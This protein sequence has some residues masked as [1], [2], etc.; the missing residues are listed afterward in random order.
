MFAA[1]FW[2]PCQA[3]WA[4]DVAGNQRAF[5]AGMAHV[6]AG[7][8]QTA[9][10]VFEDL[11]GRTDAPRVRLEL[12]RTLFLA[13]EY[14]RSRAEFLIVYR[15]DLP[16]PVRR[17][18]NLFLDDID[19]RIGFVQPQLGLA[20]DDNPSQSAAS[21]T[22]EV[23][24]APL[25]FQSGAKTAVGIT[26]RL[27]ALQPLRRGGDTQ[28]Q[29][30]GSIEGAHFAQEAAS[31][32]GGFVGVRYDELR[33]GRRTTLG[34]RGYE[35]QALRASTPFVEYYRRTAL[36][37]RQLSLQGSLELNRFPGRAH[38]NGAT[39]RGAL[40]YARDL[41]PNTTGQATVG[42]S[43]SDIEDS[44]LPRTVLFGQLG[45][46]RRLPSAKTNLVASASLASSNYGARDPFFGK[47]R[48][49]LSARLDLAFYTARPVWGFFPG[50]V[51]SY[52]HHHS[53]IAFYGFDRAGLALDFRRRF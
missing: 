16:Y 34:W 48:R 36:R 51:V 13:G 38:L 33:R 19:Q 42:G 17:T 35:T 22:Y 5:A 21:G 53:N 18:I 27:D 47:D 29:A 26:Y 15:R 49:D 52:D 46:S 2:L 8:L 39:A 10:K 20:V 50:V 32:L 23:L 25:E 1:A 28:L 43:V 4:E 41:G 30:V 12:A 11:A 45:L 7:D 14:R 24:G 3:A 40:A 31:H 9:I 37:D 44:Q 6:A